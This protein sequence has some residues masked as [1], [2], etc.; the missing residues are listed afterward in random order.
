MFSF[1]RKGQD[2]K[3]ITVQEREADGFVIV[4]DTADDQNREAKDKASFPETRPVYNQPP[5]ISDTSCGSAD[6]NPVIL[7]YLLSI[8]PLPDSPSEEK[9]RILTFIILLLLFYDKWQYTEMKVQFPDRSLWYVLQQEPNGLLFS[10][11]PSLCSPS[12]SLSQ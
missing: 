4:G 11:L 7:P 2:S 9:E 10:L 8:T 5:Q 6:S 12:S 1:F 3:K